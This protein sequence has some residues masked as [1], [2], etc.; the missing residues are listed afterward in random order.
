MIGFNEVFNQANTLRHSLDNSLVQE[1][2][3]CPLYLMPLIKKELP[4]FAPKAQVTFSE[5]PLDLR[6]KI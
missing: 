3:H 4:S 6:I 1:Y 5:D 2:I